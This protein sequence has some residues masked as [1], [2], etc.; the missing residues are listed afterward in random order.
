M[1]TNGTVDHFTLLDTNTDHR[2][3]KRKGRV[4]WQTRDNDAAKPRYKNVLSLRGEVDSPVERAY[5][6]FKVKTLFTSSDAAVIKR[7][8]GG[9]DPHNLSWVHVTA[10]GLRIGR[11]DLT[12]GNRVGAMTA[13]ELMTLLKETV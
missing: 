5:T 6:S 9:A 7:E 8:L 10:I 12:L 1:K 13:G 11:K 4:I 2:L 3:V